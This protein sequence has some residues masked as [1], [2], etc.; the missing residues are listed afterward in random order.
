[1][2]SQ[3]LW[4]FDV[5]TLQWV[6]ETKDVHAW[7]QARSGHFGCVLRTQAGE[8]MLIT[9]SGFELQNINGA[10]LGGVLSD[11]WAFSFTNRTWQPR[12]PL[13]E[14]LGNADYACLGDRLVLSGGTTC[15]DVH[16]TTGET[17]DAL[18]VYNATTDVWVRPAFSEPHPGPQWGGSMFINSANGLMYVYGGTSVGEI[19]PSESQVLATS[20]SNSTWRLTLSPDNLNA[21]WYAIPNSSLPGPLLIAQSCSLPAFG[22][23]TGGFKSM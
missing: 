17:T 16:C 9:G 7:P 14:A 10:V 19:G 13:P 1:M 18:L 2:P 11:V 3:Q 20:M 23:M 21:T 6:N 4:R 22:L 15:V 12:A 8:D 5:D